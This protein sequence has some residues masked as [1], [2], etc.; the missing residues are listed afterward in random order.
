MQSELDGYPSGPEDWS[1]CQK[2]YNVRINRYQRSN[3]IYRQ[4]QLLLLKRTLG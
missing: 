1:L 4:L 3:I 2:I